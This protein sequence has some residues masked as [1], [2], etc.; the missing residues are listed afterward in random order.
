VGLLSA[1]QVD[2]LAQLR[3]VDLSYRVPFDGSRFRANIFRQ[4]HGVAAVFRVVRGHIPGLDE[5]GLPPV[6]RALGELPNGLVLVGGPTG[7]GKSTTLAALID[8]IN[9]TSARHI[10]TFEDPIEVV[11]PRAKGLVNQRELG[12][13]TRSFG[14][15]LRATLREDPDVILVGEMRDL[16]TI[17]FAVSVAETGHLVLGT[18]HTVSADTTLDR[19]VNAFP[20]GSQDQVRAMLASSLR[21]VV[22]QY[23]LPRADGRGRVLAAEV[24][25]NNDAV[26]NLI[27]KGKA[28]QLP[29]VIT[30]SRAEGMQSMDAELLRLYNNSVI[31]A[32]TAY[33][34]ARNKKEFEALAPPAPRRPEG[35]G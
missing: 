23:L 17:S 12:T 35:P 22:C 2:D 32:E 10:I 28:H 24:M 8:R 14:A 16:A 7:S 5:L 19:L 11:H 29:A 31:T 18:V 33:S 9:R 13:H 15:A 25:V 1:Q 21:A 34:K 6:V 3:D 20:A 30:T 26:A 27:R 4:I